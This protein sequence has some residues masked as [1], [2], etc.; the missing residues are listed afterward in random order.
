MTDWINIE[1]PSPEK[2]KKEK[3]KAR[4]LKKTNWWQ[5]RL[6]KGLCHYCKNK[7]KAEELTMDHI[8]PISRGGKS[9]KGNIVPCCKDCNNKKKYLTPVEMILDELENKDK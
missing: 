6:N 4:Q 7:F 8:V 5:E 3:E 1:K 2:I 9:V